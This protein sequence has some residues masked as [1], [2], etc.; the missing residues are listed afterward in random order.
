METILEISTES[1]KILQKA[2]NGRSWANSAEL[3]K[4]EDVVIH[5]DNEIKEIKI[6]YYMGILEEVY[7]IRSKEWIKKHIRFANKEFNQEF[8]T[9]LIF[10]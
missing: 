1:N 9:A 5:V 10:I 2:K 4:Y 7:D 6:S 8:Q 3:Y